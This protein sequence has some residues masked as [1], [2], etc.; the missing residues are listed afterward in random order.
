MSTGSEP[1]LVQREGPIGMLI[2]NR[3][4]Q[5]NAVTLDMWRALPEILA[6]AE[7][8][9]AV[10]VLVLRGSGYRAFVAGADIDELDDVSGDA[11]YAQASEIAL[12]AL[13]RLH[14]PT[15][16]LIHGHCVGA[17]V[18]LA[19]ACDLRFASDDARFSVPAVR[20]GLAVRVQTAAR[21][22][23]V[24]GPTH[25]SDILLSGRR[26]DALEARRMGLVNHVVAASEVDDAVEQAARQIADNAPLS[27]RA[28]KLALRAALEAP[29]RV[30]AAELDEAI[31]A[32]TQS[33]DRAEG[34][35]ALRN[36]RKPR[37][38]GR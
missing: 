19:L 13:T 25:A 21:L 10:R 14:K 15:L 4:E 35:R 17:G 3:P 2:V 36:K 32:C 8:D 22:A 11:A 30:D 1:W 28:A 27:L 23:R 7:A 29:G 33:A 18:A 6:A 34:G 24:V 12:D 5:H 37:F 20:F 38:T 16:A 26:F 31:D 9:E